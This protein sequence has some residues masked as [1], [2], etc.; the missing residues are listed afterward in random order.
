MAASGG[1]SANSLSSLPPHIHA[2]LRKAAVAHPGPDA[3]TALREA[4]A[5]SGGTAGQRQR[6]H[7]GTCVM[8][9]LLDNPIYAD[10]IAREF[11]H[12]VVEHHQKWEPLTSPAASGSM[13]G[14]PYRSQGKAYT[15][16]SGCYD[17]GPADKIVDWA[18]ER[19]LKVKGHTLCWH[20][21]SPAWL[22][23]LDGAQCAEALRRHIFTTCGHF[24]GRVESWDVVNEALAPDGALAD[25]V[26]LR[27]MGPGYIAQAFR[28]AKEADPDALLLYNDNKVEGADCGG[29]TLTCSASSATASSDGDSE[30]GPVRKRAKRDDSGREAGAEQYG[31][32]A[33]FYRKSD[34]M[35]ELLKSLLAEGV[36]IDGVGLQAHF[37]AAGV[38]LGRCPTPAAVAANIRRLAALGTAERP[39]LVNI[40]EMD[41]RISKLPADCSE[42]LRTVAQCQIYHDVLAAAA[43]SSPSFAGITLWGFT[44]KHTWVTQFYHAD[45]PLIFDEAFRRKP[46]Y[47]AVRDALEA[48][49]FTFT[50]ELHSRDGDGRPNTGALDS[51]ERWGQMWM[52]PEPKPEPAADGSASDSAAGGAAAAAGGSSLPDWQQPAASDGTG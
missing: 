45:S 15:A 23:D 39:F 1:P 33:D 34:A 7:V 20:V 46:S 26:F 27:K 19:G 51:E 31:P 40:S 30:A 28:W 5:G 41:V 13:W 4:A 50:F 37:N 12:V 11:T 9:D 36:Q 22:E 42:H 35:F 52:Q 49:P 32:S 43:A 6:L 25:N 3:S 10:T 47:F 24:R 29:A 2:V 38:G 18:L 48:G 44:D 21:T 16:L 8:P 14:G 17:F